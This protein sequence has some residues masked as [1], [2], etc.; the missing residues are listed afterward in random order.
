M[1]PC[2]VVAVGLRCGWTFLPR[3]MARLSRPWNRIE[4][5]HFLACLRVVRRNEAADTQVAAADADNDLVLDHER[6]ER[7]RV[8]RL[9]ITHRGTPPLAPGF[10]IDGDE[11]RIE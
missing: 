7:Q 11:A 3:F 2:V 4:A 1:H 6:C 5:P 8:A 9:H 10:G